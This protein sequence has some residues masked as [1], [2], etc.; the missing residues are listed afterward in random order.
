MKPLLFCLIAI[1]LFFAISCSSFVGGA[2]GG[3]ND[4]CLIKRATQLALEY[5]FLGGPA[6]WK[7]VKRG[8]DIPFKNQSGNNP[9]D[10]K[11]ILQPPTVTRE[12]GKTIVTLY[13]WTPD[14]GILARWDV[15]VEGETLKF[16][17][18]EV[19]DHQIGDYIPIGL[20]GRW[21]PG[22]GKL[23]ANDRRDEPLPGSCR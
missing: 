11:D 12:D 9:H 2:N 20:E 22:K 1:L 3:I 5:Q 17:H 7:I 18:A 19:I 6:D 8:R 23:L 4:Q 16:L 21:Q 14:G 15:Q 13:L 10:Y